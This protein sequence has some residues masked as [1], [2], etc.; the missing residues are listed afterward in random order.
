[1][2]KQ[3]SFLDVSVSACLGVFSCQYLA[4]SLNN[5]LGLHFKLLNTNNF[6]IPWDIFHLFDQ[7]FLNHL[8]YKIVFEIGW[9]FLHSITAVSVL[10]KKLAWHNPYLYSK[11]VL[12]SRTDWSPPKNLLKYSIAHNNLKA[13]HRHSLKNCCLP[14][15]ETLMCTLLTS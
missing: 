13:M 6:N 5:E 15:S 2:G 11:T 10:I 9:T 12:P 14:Q 8:F 4:A 3:K 1:M 7:C